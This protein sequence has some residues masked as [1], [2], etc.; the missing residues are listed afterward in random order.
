[1]SE[2]KDEDKAEDVNSLVA[3]FQNLQQQLQSILMQKETFNLNK[4]EIER[5]LEELEKASEDTAYKI[6]GAIMVKKPVE[7]LKKELNNTKEV[8]DIKIKSLE[9]TEKQLTE[10]LKNLQEKLKKIVK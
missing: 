2:K 4:I 3:K 8:V 9:K 7:E 5:A 6:T 10:Q 1:M